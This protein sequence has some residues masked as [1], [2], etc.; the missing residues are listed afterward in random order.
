MQVFHNRQVFRE[1]SK[2]SILGYSA[3]FRVLKSYML[4][5]LPFLSC[6]LAFGRLLQF[7]YIFPQFWRYFMPI[8]LC[9]N[10][11]GRSWKLHP[12]ACKAKQ[13]LQQCWV[14]AE[15]RTKFI[16]NLICKWHVSYTSPLCILGYKWNGFNSE[17]RASLSSIPLRIMSM[18]NY[19]THRMIKWGFSGVCVAVTDR[20]TDRQKDRHARHNSCLTS[21]ADAHERL[22]MLP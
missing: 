17:N 5:L 12:N 19:G 18:V 7:L 20:Q 22:L 2:N 13:P 6:A 10:G 9:S 11:T 8:L 14:L 21:H 3:P 15:A 4:L 1:R 16:Q